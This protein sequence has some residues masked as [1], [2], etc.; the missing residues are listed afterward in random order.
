[1]RGVL[2]YLLLMVIPLLGIT[3]LILFKPSKNSKTSW[4]AFMAKGKD[5]GFSFREIDLLRKLAIKSHLEDPAAL[6]WSQKQLDRCISAMLRNARLSGEDRRQST[7]DFIAK[8]YEYRKKIEFE[9]PQYKKG[10]NNSRQIE[11]GQ[12]IRVLA[13]SMGVYKSRVIKNTDHYMTI[14]RPVSPNLPLSFSWNGL[15]IAVYF[16]RRDDAGYVF[17][18]TVTDEVYSRGVQA[19]QI[20]HAESLFR[21]QKRASIRIKTKKPAFLYLPDGGALNET[22]ETKPG[23][24]CIVEDLSDSGCAVTIGGKALEGLKV[25]IQFALSDTP[26]IMKGT[27]RSTEFNE[28]TSRSLL[29]IEADPLPLAIRNRILGEVF[30]VQTEEDY[31]VPFQLLEEEENQSKL[32]DEAVSFQG[33]SNEAPQ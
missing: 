23:L 25:K 24:K 22:I 5:A 15:K 17:D 11:E 21:T 26:I 7:Q 19:L 18:A 2:I 10:I 32:Q 31:L 20:N 4:I 6:F 33:D 12:P 1:M 27:V 8:L 16:W 3:V 14:T 29:H 28:E 13:E 30:G 9:K